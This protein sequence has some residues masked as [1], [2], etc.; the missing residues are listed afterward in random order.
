MHFETNVSLTPSIERRHH[1]F[2]IRIFS[3][4]RVSKMHYECSVSFF[5]TFLF[6]LCDISV[7][8]GPGHQDYSVSV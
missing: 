6:P 2:R 8:Y 5:S 3:E 1:H 4:R 7:I